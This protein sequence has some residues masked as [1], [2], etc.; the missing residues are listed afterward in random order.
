MN[1]PHRISG[2]DFY[3]KAFSKAIDIK[4]AFAKMSY[5]GP[6]VNALCLRY[7]ENFSWWFALRE[8]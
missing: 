1:N 8:L 4:Q 7:F 2:V 6:S 5:F 3:E